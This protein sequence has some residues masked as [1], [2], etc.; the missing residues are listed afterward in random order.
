MSAKGC[1]TLASNSSASVYF[2]CAANV[3][4]REVLCCTSEKVVVDDSGSIDF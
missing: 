3:T 2:D 4:A 1:S